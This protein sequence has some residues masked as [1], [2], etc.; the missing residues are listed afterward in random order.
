MSEQKPVKR[1][2]CMILL[3][4]CVSTEDAPED[5]V[6]F[7]FVTGLVPVPEGASLTEQVH[8]TVRVAWSVR[9]HD[10]ELVSRDGKVVV[11]KPAAAAEMT[12]VGH[13]RQ[14][15]LSDSRWHMEGWEWEA[16]YPSDD[17]CT[18]EWDP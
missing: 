4:S 17:T 9:V 7:G 8:P 2:D 15:V 1:G 6:K 14:H 13:Q 5:C 11:L 3:R 10:A 16:A 18:L 12:L